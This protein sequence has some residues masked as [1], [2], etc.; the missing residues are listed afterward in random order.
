MTTERNIRN[1]SRLEPI[2]FLYHKMQGY[3]D[4]ER[5]RHTREIPET[6]LCLQNAKWTKLH[7]HEIPSKTMGFL[8]LELV[9]HLPAMKWIN[10]SELA[11]LTEKA[12]TASI[13]QHHTITMLRHNII[14]QFSS[15]PFRCWFCHQTN[16]ASA[17]ECSSCH[18]VVLPT[19]VPPT[20]VQP[21]TTV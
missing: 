1:R 11:F 6:F 19:M 10:L 20:T 17:T 3:R 4:E 12:L 5:K 21:P 16:T 18:A 8:C 9:T 13:F 2:D 14:A 15:S 7:Y